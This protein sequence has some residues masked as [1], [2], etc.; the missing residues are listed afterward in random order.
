[1]LDLK[2]QVSKRHHHSASEASQ[3]RFASTATAGAFG[4]GGEFRAYR[5]SRAVWDPS[6]LLLWYC[7]NKGGATR[8]GVTVN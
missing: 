5:I 2:H 7:I 3:K 8:V 1:M 6:I 4:S